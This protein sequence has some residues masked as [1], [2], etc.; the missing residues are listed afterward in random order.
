MND[1]QRK[2][3]FANKRNFSNG[4]TKAQVLGEPEEHNILIDEHRKGTMVGNEGKRFT[5]PYQYAKNPAELKK[6]ID[7]EKKDD[8]NYDF[9]V[10]HQEPFEGYHHKASQFNY[11]NI[12]QKDLRGKLSNMYEMKKPVNRA[13]A[14]EADKKIN[15]HRVWAIDANGMY[16][17]NMALRRWLVKDGYS[18]GLQ[19]VSF[20][21]GGSNRNDDKDSPDYITD[22]DNYRNNEANIHNI[23]AVVYWQDDATVEQKQKVQAVFSK[24]FDLDLNSEYQESASFADADVRNTKAWSK[25][26]GDKEYGFGQLDVES[27]R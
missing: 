8:P 25:K 14:S 24:Y 1:E 22:H 20:Y 19:S 26:I 9:D 15:P 11:N 2:A 23:Q 7:K 17:R 10:V 21:S 18:S 27:W 5:H 6:H 4:L 13:K 12:R 16:E 3:M